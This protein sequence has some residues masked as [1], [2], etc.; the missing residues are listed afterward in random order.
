MGNGSVFRRRGY[1]CAVFQWHGGVGRKRSPKGNGHFKH[2]RHQGYVR[3]ERNGHGKRLGNHDGDPRHNRQAHRHSG[4]HHQQRRRAQ[5]HD[6]CRQCGQAGICVEQ[7]HDA[8]GLRL[9]DFQQRNH[10]HGQDRP[11]RR[12]IL[13]PCPRHQFRRRDGDGVEKR[14]GSR[15]RSGRGDLP[16][17][18]GQLG[19]HRLGQNASHQREPLSG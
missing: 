5:R 1:K 18:D 2:R 10:R 17:A 3:P 4:N 6:H 9:G 8:P 7:F 11:G 16:R 15:G 19:Q 13:P 14:D 12:N